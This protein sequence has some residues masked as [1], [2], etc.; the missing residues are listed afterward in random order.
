MGFK[1]KDTYHLN[2]NHSLRK[3]TI[4]HICNVHMNYC[5]CIEKQ[6]REIIINETEKQT[7]N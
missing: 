7:R 1:K 6:K 5:E 3:F 4:C 2:F